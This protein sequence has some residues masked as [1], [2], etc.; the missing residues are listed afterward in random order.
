MRALFLSILLVLLG[1][2]T[3]GVRGATPA[4]QGPGARSDQLLTLRLQARPHAPADLP[5]GVI[6]LRVP[7]YPH[8]RPWLHHYA[9]PLM[10]STSPYMKV[11]PQVDFVLPADLQT[12][13]TWYLQAFARRSDTVQVTIGESGNAGTGVSGSWT[14]LDFTPRNSPTLHLQLA[15]QGVP[16]GTI[17]AYEASAV[18][19]PPR[20][21]G[22]YIAA[23]VS[24]VTMTYQFLNTSSHRRAI[25]Y[26]LTRHD[27]IIRLVRAIN[28]LARSDGA[29]TSCPFVDR[30]ALLVFH[31]P[32]GR[33]ITAGTDPGCAGVVITGYPPLAGSIWSLLTSLVPPGHS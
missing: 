1:A 31:Y 32:G 8:A 13:K 28:A 25:T 23:G 27:A 19:V 26:A 17:A 33:S 5:A 3:T 4:R 11:S 16:G 21:P 9:M 18:T 30:Q 22:S 7:L 14:L 2:A 20:V 10:T 15:L 24:R 29:L 6:I 12:A